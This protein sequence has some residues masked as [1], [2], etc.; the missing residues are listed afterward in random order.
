MDYTKSNKKIKVF[1][2]DKQF[3]VEFTSQDF[4]VTITT[5]HNNK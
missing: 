2:Y 4:H 3:I 1:V 5:W